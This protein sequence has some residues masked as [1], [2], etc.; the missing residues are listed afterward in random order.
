MA[1]PHTVREIKYRPGKEPQEWVCE[2]ID[3]DPPRWARLRYVTDQPYVIEGIE[4]PVGTV[5]DAMYWKDRPYHV[6]KFTGPDGKQL[7]YRFDVCT[8][9]FIWPEKLI[10]TDLEA[11]L[12]ISPDGRPH[13]QDVDDMTQLV[14]LEHLGQEEFA[15]AEEGRGRLERGWKDVIREVYGDTV[16]PQSA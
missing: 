16:H 10:W 5:T 11:D 3:M 13:W 7:G 6:W 14:Q 12:Y 8:N 15:A 4:L 1:A 9:T 2:V